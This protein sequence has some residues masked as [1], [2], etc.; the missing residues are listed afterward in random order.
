MPG[1]DQPAMDPAAS[2]AAPPS[3][4]AGASALD[5]RVRRTRARLFEAVVLLASEQPVE[6]ITVADLVR[7]ARVNRTTFYKHA[8]SP[9][10]VLEQVLYADLDRVRAE[11]INDATAARLPVDVVWERASGA[12]L[13]HLERHE[14]VYTAGLVGRRS[15]ILHHLLVD[16]FATSVRT[17]LDRDPGLLPEGEGPAQWRVQAQSSFL[18]H[19]ETGLVEAWLSRPAPRDRRLFVSAASEALPAWLI[20]GQGTNTAGGPVRGSG[21]RA[22]AG[23]PPGARPGTA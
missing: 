10:E 5:V 6:D 23:P 22:D 20:R 21:R 4:A 15:A 3:S 2:D 1:S 9:A 19:G 16:H 8:S 12:L 18:A 14:A 17:L 11:W 13:D 7:T